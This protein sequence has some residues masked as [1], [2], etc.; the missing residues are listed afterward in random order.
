MKIFYRYKVK[1]K[2]FGK[3]VLKNLLLSKIFPKLVKYF[4]FCIVLVLILM[5]LYFYLHKTVSESV[6]VSESEI[7]NK[8]SKQVI[9]PQ[10]GL[11]SVKR[12]QDAITLKNQN[13]FYKDIKI[14][15]YIIIYKTKIVIYDFMK[16]K[17]M[18]VKD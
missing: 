12:V 16:D 1:V 18:G 17:V 11:V 13:E 6:I 2:N 5:S 7:L 8:V 10:D 4:I 9:L 14:G 3:K 15:D